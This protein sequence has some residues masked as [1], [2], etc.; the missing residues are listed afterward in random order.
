MRLGYVI[1]RV[2]LSKQEASY[3]GGRFLVVQ[4]LSV[5]QFQGGPVSPLAPGSSVV[6]YDRLGAGVGAMVGFTEG[7]EASMPFEQPT[8]IDAYNAAIID[9]VFYRPPTP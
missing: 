7:S 9:R 5:R 1:G 4:P 6:V 8:P 3:T 2:T